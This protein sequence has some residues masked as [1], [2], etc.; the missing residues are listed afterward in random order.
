MKKNWYNWP[1]GYYKKPWKTWYEILRAVVALPFAMTFFVLFYLVV[2]FGW[3]Y[4]VAEE[5]RKEIF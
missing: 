5:I 4:S 1:Q 2:V 3:G